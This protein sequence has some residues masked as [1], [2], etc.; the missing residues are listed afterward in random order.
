[1][2]KFGLYDVWNLIVDLNIATNDEVLLVMFIN[3]CT[4]ETLNDI[5]YVRTGYRDIEQFL[6]YEE[7][8]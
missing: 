4:I 5:I 8:D 1:M 7:E 6:E 2:K 3:G